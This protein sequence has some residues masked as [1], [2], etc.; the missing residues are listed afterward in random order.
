MDKAIECCLLPLLPLA[1]LLWRFVWM[2]HEARVLCDAG[3]EPK[4]D[5]E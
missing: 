2:P 3:R 4:S 1:W 5:F